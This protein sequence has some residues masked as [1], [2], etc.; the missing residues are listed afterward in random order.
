MSI[1]FSHCRRAFLRSSVAAFVTL[2]VIAGCGGE[3]TT[4]PGSDPATETFASSLGVDLAS[5][6]KVSPDLYTKDL[7]V[8]TG[9]AVANNTS[10][11]ATYTG[12]LTNGTQF[13]SNV[14]GT[15]IP[16]QV[17]AGQ[18]I[19]GWDEGLVGMRVGG[20]RLLVI[21]SALAYGAGG[22]GPIPLNA[23]LVFHVKILTAQ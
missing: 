19:R 1:A 23:T 18:V 13:D 7:T 20:E 17:G 11:T 22:R 9:A 6:T 4:P 21:G 5:M 10:V 2:A 3:T 12:W 8:G 14:G 16:F 15:P